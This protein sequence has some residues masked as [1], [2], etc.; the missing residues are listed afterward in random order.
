MTSIGTKSG[1][2]TAVV[3]RWLTEAGITLRTRS[4]VIKAEYVTHGANKR[5]AV[6]QATSETNH[7]L[8]PTRSAA[9]LHKKSVARKISASRLKQAA[10][11][12]EAIMQTVYCEWCQEELRRLPCKVKERN[13]CNRNHMMKHRHSQ[14]RLL[15]EK[16]PKS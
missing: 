7:E 5:L 13:F 8:A 9:H 2:S 16:Q 6:S 4:E 12:R 3:K 11:K 15:Q 14:K 10:V 1:V